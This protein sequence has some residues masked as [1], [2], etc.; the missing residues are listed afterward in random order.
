LSLLSKFGHFVLKSVNI[1]GRKE[2]WGCIG[3]ADSGQGQ[4]GRGKAKWPEGKP[5][6]TGRKGTQ[7][8]LSAAGSI[9]SRETK[10]R[11]VER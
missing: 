7:S 2:G 6:K 11:K 1:D 10:A 5:E 4:L 3:A 8:A 9:E